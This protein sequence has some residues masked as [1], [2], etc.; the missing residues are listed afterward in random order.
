MDICDR[1]VND[2]LVASGRIP[3]SF[4]NR[5]K[6][7]FK[8]I[9]CS[10]DDGER[11]GTGR[12]ITLSDFYVKRRKTLLH[13]AEYRKTSIMEIAPE[14]NDSSQPLCVTLSYA[15]SI[16]PFS[17]N[18]DDP[19]QKRFILTAKTPQSFGAMLGLLSDNGIDAAAAISAAIPN[20]SPDKG[21]IMSA[22]QQSALQKK[23][24][25]DAIRNGIADISSNGSL[26][27]GNHP[28]MECL[29]VLK[30][31]K[32]FVNATDDDVTD[33]ILSFLKIPAADKTARIKGVTAASFADT[34][35]YRVLAEQIPAY[36]HKRREYMAALNR[37]VEGMSPLDFFPYMTITKA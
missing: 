24:A 21:I 36:V 18:E 31:T 5:E 2:I 11:Y 35:S 17:A 32:I 23:T 7:H 12:T 34:I 10:K 13:P 4:S 3:S 29:S 15:A 22:V 16:F 9:R 26:T 20:S 30:G 28:G 19:R 8:A 14:E 25:V 27:L 1:A 37:L 6:K 33:A